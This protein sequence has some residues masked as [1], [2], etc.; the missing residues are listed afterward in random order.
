MSTRAPTGEVT[1]GTLVDLAATERLG[2]ALGAAAVAGDCI[3]LDGELGAGKTTLSRA[4]ALTFG[5]A[6]PDEFASPTYT[7]LNP[8]PGPQGGVLHFDFYRLSG[9][10]DAEAL[11][12]DEQ[13]RRKDALLVVE[14]A[15]LLA[16]LLP[17]DALWL[18]LRR[19]PAGDGRQWEARGGSAHLR[20]ALHAFAQAAPAGEAPGADH[21]PA[22]DDGA[23]G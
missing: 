17:A 9:V 14:W 21:A 20:A 19:A 15:S 12:L 5:L 22:D 18:R 4:L 11:G 13:L 10:E 2:R 6:D 7:Y 23:S 1:V 8:Y 3:A 16:E